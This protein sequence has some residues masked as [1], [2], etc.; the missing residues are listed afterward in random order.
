MPVFL[1]DDVCANVGGWWGVTFHLRLCSLNVLICF[2]FLIPHKNRKRFHSNRHSC[3]SS[4][5]SSR[6]ATCWSAAPF[7]WNCWRGKVGVRLTRWKH[8]SCRL[9]PLWS[10]VKRA[11]SSALPRA[12]TVWLVP[13]SPSSR[14]CRFTRRTAGSRRQKKTVNYTAKMWTWRDSCN[15]HL[16]KTIP[17][18]KFPPPTIHLSIYHSTSTIVSLPI[19]CTVTLGGI[20]PV[21]LFELMI[22]LLWGARLYRRG[23]QQLIPLPPPIS[24]H[25]PVS[26]FFFFFF[27]SFGTSCRV[28][29]RKCQ[30]ARRI[31]LSIAFPSRRLRI[32]GEL[33]ASFPPYFFF[34]LQ[35][36][37]IFF[38]LSIQSDLIW[39]PKF[40][41]PLLPQYSCS[42][43]LRVACVCVCVCVITSMK[44]G[45]RAW[46]LVCQKVDRR[47]AFRIN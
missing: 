21:F 4:T 46:M 30:C 1:L 26:D 34:F 18:A 23:L 24:L 36:I 40:R 5:P 6:A 27:L 45:L 43:G 12:S 16:K 33:R 9:P 37:I 31:C 8:L 15:A 47:K 42:Y 10:K 44:G 41:C 39:I 3:A 22:F 19:F 29:V 32:T 28:R 25:S 35:F 2:V 13:N 14:S 11:S 7:A 17:Q 38:L 20:W